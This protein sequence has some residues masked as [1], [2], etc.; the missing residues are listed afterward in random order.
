MTD[1]VEGKKAGDKASAQPVISPDSAKS[2]TAVDMV[3]G[4]AEGEIEGFS[5][6]D[7][8]L[9]GTPLTAL[10][11]SIICD[12]RFG[13]NDQTHIDGL[14]D[15]SNEI[16]VG[17]ELKAT[18]PWVKQ[19][20]NQNLDAIGF[21]LSWAALRT[22]S[23][24]GDISGAT[25]KYKIEIAPTG[26]A[27]STVLEA[28]VSDKTSSDYQRYHEIPLPK[29]T[30]GW[31]LRVSRVTPDSTSD[32]VSDKMYIRAYNEIIKAKFTYPYTALVRLKYDAEMFANIAKVSVEAKG[33]KIKVPSNYNPE[34]G[35]VSGLWDGTFKLAY[36][37]NPAWVYYDL[38]TNSR[39]GLGQ[40]V[41]STM[42]DKWSLYRLAQYCDQEVDD[43]YGGL[44]RRFT[45][46]LYIQSKE[47]AFDIVTRLA[48]LFR[49]ITFWDGQQIICDAD[50]PQDTYYL[51]TN[52]NVK[53]GL[54]EYASAPSTDK[55]SAAIVAWDNPENNYETEYE[56]VIID[57]LVQIYGYKPLEID[58]WGC[59]SRGQA[60]RAGRWALMAETDSV[61]FSVGLEGFI[62]IPGKVIE[63]QDELYSGVQNGGRI[64]EISQDLKTVKL[65]KTVEALSGDEFLVNA[66]DKAVKK[67]VDSVN[68][69]H[70]T[71]KRAF[72]ED[73]IAIH[74]AWVL[75]RPSIVAQKF[76]ILTIKKDDD[77]GFTISALRYN[78]KK[79][80]EIDYNL[81]LEK[82]P[83]SVV[84][85]TAQS[86]VQNVQIEPYD[87]VY[88]GLTNVN[89]VIKWERPEHAVKYLVEWKKD[90]GS[91]IKMPITGNNSIEIEKVYAGNYI[92]RVTAISAFDLY[93][94]PTI[95][96][97]TTVK[98]KQTIPSPPL[99]LKASTDI[100]FGIDVSWILP[101]NSEDYSF[102]RIAYST[103]NPHETIVDVD[104]LPYYDKAY[105]DTVL[106]I[107]G[108]SGS[109]KMWFK[110][111]S[112]DKLGL[113]SNWTDWT[114]GKAS[115]DPD[116][117]L[118]I[119]KGHIGIAELDE[120]LAKELDD[121]NALAVTAQQLAEQAKQDAQNAKD[122]ARD[123]INELITDVNASDAAI[124]E[125]VAQVKNE[126]KNAVNEVNQNLD[127]E[128]N[129]RQ[130]QAQQM[131]NGITTA[132][133]TAD[134]AVSELTNFKAS[135]AQSLAN[136]QSEVSVVATATE[137]NTNRVNQLD[138]TLQTTTQTA[139]TALEKA[140]TATSATNALA[141][142]TTALRANI[143]AAV[144]SA[145]PQSEQ[146]NK[147]TALIVPRGTIGT[148]QIPSYEHL[149]NAMPVVY[150]YLTQ[151]LI[152]G[153]SALD[154]TIGFFRTIV[155][156]AETRTIVLN[157]FVGDD[158]HAIYL[159]GQLYYSNPNHNG[160]NPST[161]SINLT[162]GYHI[163]DFAFN[164]GIGGWGIKFSNSLA[165]QLSEMYAV[166]I[167]Y[168][169]KANSSYVNN[170]KATADT[171]NN[172]ASSALTKIESLTST[173]GNNSAQINN[174][175]QTK[176]DSSTLIAT[177]QQGLQ[178]TWQSDANAAV[179][180]LQIGGINLVRFSKGKFQPK[181]NAIDN[182]VYDVAYAL[183]ETGQTYTV[184]ARTNGVFTATHNE[185]TTSVESN[186]AAMWVSSPDGSNLKVISDA[187]TA[188]TGTTFVWDGQSG[189]C[190]I[191][192]N[193]YKADN[194][195]WI[196][197]IQI[198]R[199][200]KK[201]DWKQSIYDTEW[202]VVG[203]VHLNEM[204][205]TGKFLVQGFGTTNSPLTP[206]F[207]LIVENA[208]EG[209]VLQTVY[210]DSNA[211]EER[212]N[213]FLYDDT[214]SP[215]SKQATSKDLSDLAANVSQ[216]Y[217]T[218]TDAQQAEAYLTQQL[219]TKASQDSLNQT[220]A[221]IEN[222]YATKSNVNE[223][224]AT[225]S[226]ALTSSFQS[227]DQNIAN[228]A[229]QDATNKA[230]NATTQAN[231]YTRDYAFSK[232]ETNNA[233]S[234]SLQTYDASVTIGGNNLYR[235]T[236]DWSGELWENKWKYEAV[237]E[238]YKG[239]KVLRSYSNWAGIEQQ[240]YLDL[241]VNYTLSAW[242]RKSDANVPIHFWGDYL[243][244]DA[245]AGTQKPM[246][247]NVWTRV[248]HTFK[249]NG[250][251]GNG[252][253]ERVEN[254][255]GGYYDICGLKLERG[256]KATD[257]SPNPNDAVDG[258]VLGGRNLFNRNVVYQEFAG[259]NVVAKYASGFDV[260]GVNANNAVLRLYNMAFPAGD[261]VI[262]FDHFIGIAPFNLTFDVNDGAEVSFTA[263]QGWRH[264]EIVVKNTV[265]RTDGWLDIGGLTG[266]L[267]QFR[268]FMVEKGNKA[269]A[270]K[271][272]P[273]DTDYAIQEVQANL[274]NFQQAQASVDQAQTQQLQSAFSRLN[275]N[276]SGIEEI[277]QTKANK[278]EV[279]S[280]V[281]TNLRS[282]WQADAQAKVDAAANRILINSGTTDLN[283]IR[284]KGKYFITGS[285]TNSPVDPW[286]YLDVDEV[287]GG[288]RV[289]QKLWKDNNLSLVYNRAFVDNTFGAWVKEITSNDL[290]DFASN[291][292]QT[293]QTKSSANETT[294][295]LTQS[296]NSKTSPQDVNALL[297]AKVDAKDITYRVNLNDMRT[298]GLYLLRGG[299]DNGAYSADAWHW[300][301]VKGGIVENRVQQTMYP[302]NSTGTV[303]N[304]AWN[305]TWSE[306]NTFANTQQVNGLR[307]EVQN[308][309]STKTDTTNAIAQ[310]I[311][312]Y[313]ASLGSVLTYKLASLGLG[314]G[315]WAGINN[316]VD[317]RM[318]N[319]GR[320][321][322]LADFYN[323]NLISFENFDLFQG[324]KS[325]ELA[326]RI[327]AI[328]DNH[329]IAV[330]TYDEPATGRTDSL[331]QAFVSI[332]GTSESF[333]RITYRGAYMLVGRK[334]LREGG[335]LEL[336]SDGQHLEYILQF[337]NGVPVG[338]GGNSSTAQQT[339]A[340]A[341]VIT[342]TQAQVGNIQ[343]GLNTLSQQTTTLTSTVNTLG[344]TSSN[345]LKNSDFS[346][347]LDNWYFWSN[348]G[349]GTGIRNPPDDWAVVA[350]ESR[351]AEVHVGGNS[352]QGGYACIAQT[353]PVV[354]GKWYQFSAFTGVHRSSRHIYSI[355]WNDV[356]G[357]RIANNNK[358][359]TMWAGGRKL[360]DYYNGYLNLKAP[361]NA[362]TASF[363][364]GIGG[365]SDVYM[366][367]TRASICQVANEQSA[368]VPWSPSSA[369][370]ASQLKTQTAT[371]Q[372]QAQT[373]DGIQAKW[374]VKINNNGYAAGFGLISTPNNGAIVS[375]FMVDADAFVVG[376]AGTN[377]KPIV[378]VSGGQTV[379]GI[380]YPESGTYLNTAW[381]S[382]ASIGTAHIGDSAI[383][384]AK[385]QNGAITNA[386]IENGA[387]TN[388]KI[389]VAEI[390]TLRI[391]G[392]AVT[393]PYYY[394]DTNPVSIDSRFGDFPVS[395]NGS[396]IVPV[397]SAFSAYGFTPYAEVF[398]VCD[399]GILMSGL[400]N[401]ANGEAVSVRLIQGYYDTASGNTPNAK[402]I[403]RANTITYYDDPSSPNVGTRWE[404]TNKSCGAFS[405]K[406]TADAYGNIA[407][408]LW[409]SS[410]GSVRNSTRLIVKPETEI[411]W[412]V[413]ELKR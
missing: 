144:L 8:S 139:A 107:S 243:A 327:N 125:S 61:T 381:I 325:D 153:S 303:T 335:G 92:A 154:N 164:N 254:G 320:S 403:D 33:L 253:F 294:A 364:I 250:Q 355:W 104:T 90:D 275:N 215:W 103:N 62:P 65:D 172:N 288:T 169:D 211:N 27:Y 227:A 386:K 67:I 301:E 111:K 42:I 409:V 318:Y 245:G 321:Y 231:S 341:S 264:Y 390:D 163:L 382:K 47:R 155:G 218:K 80:D 373:I 160:A 345:L 401:S 122:E 112:I 79:F 284:T 44:E 392:R 399:V 187:N 281:E 119:I 201:T 100:L 311:N 223:S 395:S 228:N 405:R 159:D 130:Q 49:A 190:P 224:V 16:Q 133:Q 365:G 161:V 217:Q 204:K 229:A 411:T 361:D 168:I 185:E 140:N 132:Q 124:R 184:S 205:T 129:A 298:V 398:I 19:I 54:F 237:A 326:N 28:V 94:I 43:G 235:G 91:W 372:Q 309:Y 17:V 359:I 221:D 222:N 242:I 82:P 37:N 149:A 166:T 7:I 18:Q 351:T 334:G 23:S 342:Q 131:Q 69:Q 156:V 330:I 271:P 286:I 157:D 24:S 380:Y 290:N 118:K 270:Y 305:G 384:S 377:I 83:T 56:I 219:N 95:S 116:E 287:L 97:L 225:A 285:V 367:M 209:R 260:L 171:A 375:A 297:S 121:T 135:T 77:T 338:V 257:W 120:L 265:E 174:L 397:V 263:Q 136:V 5:R 268:N 180:A 262:S 10:S 15:V 350:D 123:A 71:V 292:S 289:T 248:T 396:R 26:Q 34:T 93:S 178:T 98:G 255:T 152:Y 306:W 362:V 293:Y 212:L 114:H 41:K 9:D 202:T 247:P 274:V 376:K 404:V 332:G 266:Q 296:I 240:L 68:G 73:E 310:G 2:T 50:I 389:G 146:P 127:V 368:L 370:V 75:N 52:A 200:T 283:S 58:A 87:I 183:L 39:Y 145:V 197:H 394:T 402:R 216:T 179:N 233:I 324:G 336:I 413:Q 251:V 236:Q 352:A 4:L 196:S 113:S 308:T 244:S 256:S 192:V 106:N 349:G 406:M 59:T 246:E 63:I 128:I 356:N 339:A 142:Q 317:E 138:S 110:A 72:Q 74:R 57:Y 137:S 388:A 371:I 353:V 331:R 46:N 35:K 269:S 96:N 126:A 101:Q 272:A 220:K 307:S 170:V 150:S 323:G 32:L 165:G 99:A 182:Y 214:W 48:G 226:Q 30:T 13:T 360:S 408:S 81:I 167:D 175:A 363:E 241:G 295:N 162:A 340:N 387:I 357:N 276:E 177:V 78:E 86:S 238:E 302:D 151:D 186:K 115:E 232:T 282:T 304:R 3:I 89:L 313:K 36:S 195:T 60:H 333:N 158:A 378:S 40:R 400:Y 188:T 337:I 38:C 88:Q 347:G 234:G 193:G 12:Y 203:D 14:D 198:E 134:G 273:E 358:D 1:F 6:S 210:K 230:N 239:L 148:Q 328:P 199:G 143:G 53:D 207:Y 66:N 194:S 315:G 314:N 249:G 258:L 319:M 279:T 76:R 346:A 11:S 312:S 191:R 147:F 316:A 141:E 173:V 208:A 299:W 105:P 393:V 366:F 385:I 261:C 410:E 407:L 25:V 176:A 267:H 252:R 329:Y 108:L 45:C 55:Y 189:W 51:F 379:E 300:L 70:L 412:Y 348:I 117:I 291:V 21:R 354:G 344:A 22:Q 85:P 277:K 280:I 374:T 369:G 213:R 29:S 109:S 343:N 84:N 391:Q 206:W 64:L 102:T 20:A 259:A 383:T 278:S 322:G 181:R 31:L